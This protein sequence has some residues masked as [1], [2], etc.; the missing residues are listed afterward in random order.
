MNVWKRLQSGINIAEKSEACRM[1]ET[2]HQI[3]RFG[4]MNDILTCRLD[5]V[6]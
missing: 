2:M 6:T 3:D 1:Y 5:G 4:K